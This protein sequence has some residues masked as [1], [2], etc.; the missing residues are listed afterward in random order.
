M[1]FVFGVEIVGSSSA[2]EEK[3]RGIVPFAIY[4]ARAIK[5]SF[6]N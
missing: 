5:G 4:I 2:L 6:H 3:N 1:S